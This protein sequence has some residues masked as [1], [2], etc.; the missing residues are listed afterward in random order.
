MKNHASG[1]F[2]CPVR[3]HLCQALASLSVCLLPAESKTLYK[4]LQLLA[5][6]VTPRERVVVLVHFDYAS[7]EL[8]TEGIR[9]PLSLKDN[10]STIS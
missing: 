8:R 5:L 3:I 4:V 6:E 10:I 7:S 1:P 2:S 9:T